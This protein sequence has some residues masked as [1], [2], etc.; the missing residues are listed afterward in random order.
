MALTEN[1]IKAAK[2]VFKEIIEEEYEE[3]SERPETSK[4]MLFELFLVAIRDGS[5]SNTEMELLRAFQQ[6]YQL[7]DFIFDDLLERAEALNNEISKTIAIIL[8]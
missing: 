6:H 8:E 7:E 4:V 3:N 1:R 2:E 5:I